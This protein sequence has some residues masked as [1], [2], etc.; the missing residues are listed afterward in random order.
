[1]RSHNLY[2]HWEQEVDGKLVQMERPYNN[3]EDP[4]PSGNDIWELEI[5]ERP[6]TTRL[7]GVLG[8]TSDFDSEGLGSIP[9][10]A[11][12]CPKEDYSNVP[13]RALVC[14]NC[15]IIGTLKNDWVYLGATC[16]QCNKGTVLL[17]PDKNNKICPFCQQGFSTFFVAYWHMWSSHIKTEKIQIDLDKAFW[18]NDRT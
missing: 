16:P 12:N 15:G 5:C 18:Y 2:Y 6:S 11:S 4:P 10:G 1:M 9:N 13:H 14:K 7:R 17:A 3:G 8:C